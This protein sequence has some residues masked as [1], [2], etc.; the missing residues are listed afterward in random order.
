MRLRGCGPG[1]SPPAGDGGRQAWG[2]GKGRAGT[3]SNCGSHHRP[4][5]VLGKAEL[6]R[7]QGGQVQDASQGISSEEVGLGGE[8]QQGRERG[9]T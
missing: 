5:A 7:A 8:R 9:K 6:S 4:A 2:Q 3:G 1:S